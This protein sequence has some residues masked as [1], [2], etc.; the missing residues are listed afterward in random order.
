VSLFVCVRKTGRQGAVKSKVTGR[1][2]RE[3][4]RA[5]ERE[6]GRARERERERKRERKIRRRQ[7]VPA[8][9]VNLFNLPLV[10]EYVSLSEG[11]GGEK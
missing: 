6:R 8:L 7:G 11:E 3:R 4:E 10:V 1:G 9:I 5:R 2:R